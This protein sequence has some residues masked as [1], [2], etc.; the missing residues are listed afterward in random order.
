MFL[1]V[2]GYQIYISFLQ[3]SRYRDQHVLVAVSVALFGCFGFAIYPIC[4]ELL[5][6]VTYPIAEATSSGLAVISG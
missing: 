1:G 6:E 5:V 2:H 3:V 4:L